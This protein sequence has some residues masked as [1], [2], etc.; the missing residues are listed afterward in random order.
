MLFRH[1]LADL[2]AIRP[3]L[4]DLDEVNV[5]GLRLSTEGLELFVDESETERALAEAKETIAELEGTIKDMEKADATEDKR[6]ADMETELDT[7]REELAALKDPTAEGSTVLTY[8]DRA[9][10]A[11]QDAEKTRE[12]CRQWD[13]ALRDKDAEL[14]AMRKRKGVEPGLMGCAHE[15]W[16]FLASLAA[17]DSTRYDPDPQATVKRHQAEAARLRDRIKARV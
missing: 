7:L 8:R 17:T 9:I 5:S 10:A 3:R 4:R 14:T 15:V 2:D 13:Q 16:C 11:E 1:F 12:R 6:V